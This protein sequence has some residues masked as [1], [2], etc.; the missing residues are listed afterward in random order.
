LPRTRHRPPGK[1]TQVA[2]DRS[3]RCRRDPFQGNAGPFVLRLAQRSRAAI[4]DHAVGHARVHHARRRDLRGAS[5][6]RIRRTGCAQAQR[7]RKR[8]AQRER[9]YA[10]AMLRLNFYIRRWLL[11]RTDYASS[12]AQDIPCSY[13]GCGDLAPRRSRH[14]RQASRANVSGTMPAG[15]NMLSASITQSQSA[16]IAKSPVHDPTDQ[17]RRARKVELSCAGW[18]D[19]APDQAPKDRR[20]PASPA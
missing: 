2:A 17:F 15:M 19:R 11:H 8:A 13:A 12:R 4:R 16:S 1:R 7:E 6:R 3:H 5:G 14:Q 9:P 20:A 10:H 18:R